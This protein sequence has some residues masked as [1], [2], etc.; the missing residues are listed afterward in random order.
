[1]LA[2]PIVPKEI[3]SERV[4]VILKLFR[5]RICQAR[6]PAHRHPHREI[7]PLRK[8]REIKQLARTNVKKANNRKGGFGRPYCC[9]ISTV[10]GVRHTSTKSTRLGQTTLPPQKRTP[11]E[12]MLGGAK[13]VASDLG[14]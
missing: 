14:F 5:E 10:A 13:I 9:E 2:S 4:T 12:W 6:N 1:V 8:G 3:E 7:L 11:S